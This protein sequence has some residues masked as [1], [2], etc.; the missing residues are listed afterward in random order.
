VTLGHRS[1][2][3]LLS[4]GLIAIA[5]VAADV[6]ITPAIDSL[7]TD[8]IRDNL[9]VRLELIEREASQMQAPLD[10]IP[11]WNALAD[12]LGQRAKARV[13]LIRGDGVVVGESGVEPSAV[14]AM[15]NHANR[16]EVVDAL[17][18]GQGQSGRYSTTLKDRRLYVAVPFRRNG[19]VAGVARISLPLTDV[20]HATAQFRSLLGLGALF[21][22][23]AAVV[24]SFIAASWAS[25]GVRALTTTAQ[26]MAQGDLSL[27][28][29]ATARDEVGQLGVALDRLA[30]SLSHSLEQVRAERDLVEGI[31]DGMH[32]GLLLLD[33][34]GR[35]AMV[36]P[37]LREML[38]WGPDVKGKAPLEVVRQSELQELINQATKSVNSA[39]SEIEFPGI[40]PRRLFVHASRLS[41]AP[42]GLLLVFVD[43]TDLRH[44]ESVRR[45]FVSNA[46]HELRTPV[47]AIRGAAETLRVAMGRDPNAA[48]KFLDIIERSSER[49]ARLTEDLL[50]LAR[51]ESRT[52]NLNPVSLDLH[53]SADASISM[54]REAAARRHIQL[55]SSLPK[56]LPLIR[57]DRRAVEQVLGN[58]IDNAI[59]YCQE[60]AEVKVLASPNGATVSVAVQDNGPGIEARHLPRLFERFY[61]VDAGRSREL[62]GTGLGLSI[63]KH[64]VEAMDGDIGVES[65]PGKGTTFQVH[66]PRA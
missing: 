44:L 58:L 46:S 30:E 45:D 59:K 18:H 64:L 36:N 25:Q 60:G 9:A 10:D 24:M 47:T 31:L 8:R 34:D 1:K 16:P 66:L 15:E 65:T 7:L 19:A 5:V 3:F 29:H 28:T 52:Y 53:N 61:R 48:A 32:E 55:R 41:R 57:A 17:A 4:V 6:Y 12:D 23:G 40:K 21:A 26:G 54:F 37:A 22:I 11:A 63:V 50:D 20:D 43:V 49:L 35:I 51:L 13:T 62:G 42:W 56:D 14:P 33:R 38:L 2:L 27:R 39:S